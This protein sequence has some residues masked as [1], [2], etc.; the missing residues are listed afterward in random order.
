MNRYYRTALVAGL[1]AVGLVAY[2]VKCLAGINLVPG[3]HGY[4]FLPLVAAV[5][6]YLVRAARP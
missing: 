3:L 5:A 6:Y 4:H 1:V 2:Q